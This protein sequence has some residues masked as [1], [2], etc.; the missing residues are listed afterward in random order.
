[1]F[2]LVL[3]RAGTLFLALQKLPIQLHIRRKAPKRVTEKDICQSRFYLLFPFSHLFKKRGYPKVSI[4]HLYSNTI[5]LYLVSFP[6]IFIIFLIKNTGEPSPVQCLNLC[7]SLKSFIN[8]WK[9]VFSSYKFY[10]SVFFHCAKWLL[11]YV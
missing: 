7:C 11:V 5:S 3:L 1:M 9:E 2:L 4:S 10:K 6:F 8:M